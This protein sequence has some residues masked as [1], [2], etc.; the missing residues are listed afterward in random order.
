MLCYSA[1]VT[2]GHGVVPGTAPVGLHASGI[3]YHIPPQ[4]RAPALYCTAARFTAPCIP[5]LAPP[6]IAPIGA[7][8]LWLK[9]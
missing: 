3:R 4:Q 6:P 8:Q 9:A 7:I 2:S 1:A 5:F